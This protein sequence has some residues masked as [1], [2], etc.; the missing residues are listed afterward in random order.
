[1]RRS[2]PDSRFT[3]SHNSRNPATESATPKASARGASSLPEGSGRCAVRRILLSATRSY[4]WLS[5]AV[6]EA[7]RPVPT[8]VWSSESRGMLWRNAHQLAAPGSPKK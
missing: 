8:M 4:H 5:A 3:P 6:P 7:S 2:T 1:M